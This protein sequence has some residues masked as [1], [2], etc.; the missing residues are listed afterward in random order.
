MFLYKNIKVSTRS[1]SNRDLNLLTRRPAAENWRSDW[2]DVAGI[3]KYLQAKRPM[4]GNDDA[5][6]DHHSSGAASESSGVA[7]YLSNSDALASCTG[8]D[9]FRNFSWADRVSSFCR[10]CC[11]CASAADSA[12]SVV[13][14]GAPVIA[15]VSPRTCS[16]AASRQQSIARHAIHER[17][18]VS[19]ADF[20]FR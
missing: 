10:F 2:T 16:Y 7:R 6:R 8:W 15:A 18:I 9:E 13:D 20:I 1:G 11:G 19:R 3:D 12:S 4:F 17:I 5:L 14:V